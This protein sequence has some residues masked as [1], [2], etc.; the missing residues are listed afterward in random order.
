V[1]ENEYYIPAFLSTLPARPTGGR[2]GH[3]TFKVIVLS[4]EHL[5]RYVYTVRDNLA[6]R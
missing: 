3:W 5:S 4:S 1:S 2:V 6:F